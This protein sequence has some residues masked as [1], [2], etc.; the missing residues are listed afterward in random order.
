VGTS[1]ISQSEKDGLDAIMDDVHATF[2]RDIVVYKFATQ[3]VVT[4]NENF[5]P[6]YHTAGTET[7][8]VN[9]PVS[10][11]LSA[12]IKYV[13]DVEQKFWNKSASSLDIKLQA[14]VGHVRIKIPASGKTL[15]ENAQRV[16]LDGDRYVIDSALRGHGLFDNKYYTIYLKPYE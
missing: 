1:L 6:L 2:A 13:D 10:G 5:N 9:T 3:T 8:I 15:F 14:P 12:R 16:D 4:T 11:V 7:S